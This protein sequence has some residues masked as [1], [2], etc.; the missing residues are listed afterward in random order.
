[1]SVRRPDARVALGPALA[2]AAAVPVLET[3]DRLRPVVRLE[4]NAPPS[5]ALAAATLYSLVARVHAHAGLEG[6]GVLG[7]NPWGAS[8]LGELPDRLAASRPPP[9]SDPA[10]EMVIGV[11]PAAQGAVLWIGGDDWTARLGRAP[12]PVAGRSGLGL[13][14]AAAFTAAEVLKVAL[15]AQMVHVP[16]GDALVWNLWDYR[17]QPAP[18]TGPIGGRLDHVVFFGAGSVGSSA[19]GVLVTQDGLTGRVAI[20]DPDTFDAERNPYRYPAATGAE[21][22]SKAKWTAGLLQAAGWDAIGCDTDVAGW[23]RAQDA[24]GVR[25]IVVSSVDTVA[26]RLHVAD[27]LARTTL[28][29]GVTGMALHIEREHCFDD[30]ACAYCEFVNAATP[31]SQ[32]QVHSDMTGL[33]VDRI[34]QL[35]LGDLVLAPE[36]M[37]QVVAAGKLHPD[38]VPEL[39]GRRLGDLIQRIYAQAVIAGPSHLATQAVTAVSTPFVS[40]MGG[41]LVVAELAKA[42]MGAPMV[43]RR[44]D[45]EMSGQPLG[46]V[47]R[48]ARDQ[49][50]QCTCRSPHRRRWATRLYGGD[51]VP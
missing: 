43:D 42:A 9:A 26:G 45:L 27:A 33:P 4:P 47:S 13:Q 40:W 30:W 34:L 2:P 22:G 18:A 25:G 8:N 15:G 17:N 28:S 36:D 29:V 11:G 44:A 3:L 1:M 12:Q 19:T 48:R 24:P 6:D 21:H 20:V 46:A 5:V 38:R 50:G 10:V 41:V 31:L 32:A 51:R 23:V 37:A 49:T 7:P 39:T 14:A 35:H 16:V